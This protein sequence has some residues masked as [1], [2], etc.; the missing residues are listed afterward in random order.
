MSEL[1]EMPTHD[2]VST[3][4]TAEEAEEKE[5]SEREASSNIPGDD[6]LNRLSD[7]S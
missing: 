3:W 1:N 6:V 2:L 4:I 7:E 5:P